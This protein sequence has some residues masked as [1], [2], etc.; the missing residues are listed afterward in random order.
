MTVFRAKIANLVGYGELVTK[1]GNGNWTRDKYRLKL[2]T[3]SVTIKQLKYALNVQKNKV[4]GK[5]IKTSTIFVTKIL[6]FDDGVTFV[7]DLC[8]LLSFATQSS[9][10]AYEFS[11]G[12]RKLVRPFMGSYNSWRPPFGSRIG[13]LSD[14]IIQTWPNYQ[15]LKRTQPLSAFIHLIDASDISDGLLEMKITTSMQC[16][17]A[18]K[19]YFALAEGAR[20]NITETSDGQFVNVKQ[21]VVTFEEL[22]RLALHD[23][24]MTLPSSFKKIKALRNALVHRGFIREADNVTRSIFGSLSPHAMHKAMFEV[25]EEVQDILREYMLRLLGYKGDYWPYSQIGNAHRTII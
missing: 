9:V 20:F 19:S 14:F 11:L 1:R 6:S 23:V 25:M 18:I 7:E 3:H 2:G 21:K 22:L 5:Q 12:S 13:K 4:R 8:W 10:A 15:R 17:E 24:G 16:L